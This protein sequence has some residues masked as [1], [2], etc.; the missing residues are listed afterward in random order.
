MAFDLFAIVSVCMRKLRVTVT[1]NIIIFSSVDTFYKCIYR[2][3]CSKCF[4]AVNNEP[5]STIN[6]CRLK[7][8][9]DS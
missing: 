1:I 8:L 9:I 5:L 7:R 2:D 4:V 3:T 6:Y